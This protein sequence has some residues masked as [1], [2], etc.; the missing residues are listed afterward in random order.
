MSDDGVRQAIDDVEGLD[1]HAAGQ[2]GALQGTAASHRLVTTLS[3][4]VSQA[5]SEFI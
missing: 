1:F 5:G 2:Q 4:S 3:Q